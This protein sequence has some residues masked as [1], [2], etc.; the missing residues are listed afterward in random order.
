MK[1]AM[2]RIADNVLDLKKVVIPHTKEIG[3]Y[4]RIEECNLYVVQVLGVALCPRS[5]SWEPHVEV[6]TRDSRDGDDLATWMIFC[7]EFYDKCRVVLG[8]PIAH[9]RVDS[10]AVD[11]VVKRLYDK[12]RQMSDDMIVKEYNMYAK[13]HKFAEM[14]YIGD[15][16]YTFKH[17]TT[18]GRATAAR[19]NNQTKSR[20]VE[21]NLLTKLP[22][23]NVPTEIN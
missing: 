7:D 10:P 16:N 2:L 5:K 20:N 19:L 21:A 6:L 22:D 18:P 23:G 13:Y 4:G 15:M 12:Q 8:Y 14:T 1:E 9:K 3:D 11:N 17:E